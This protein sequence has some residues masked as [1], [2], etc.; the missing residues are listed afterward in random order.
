MNIRTADLTNKDYRIFDALHRDFR[1]AE[2]NKKDEVVR[3]KPIIKSFEKYAEYAE[4]EWI[5]FAMDAGEVVGYLI[6]TPY[7]DLSVKLH[8]IYISSEHQR[9]GSGREFVCLL[10]DLLKKEG[11]K[12]ITLISYNAVTDD[13]W[14]KCRFKSVNGSEQFEFNIQ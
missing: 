13:F 2:S 7:E 12:K 3:D 9:H 6:I 5:Y 8:E 4:N 14:T 1:Y 10:K 11:F